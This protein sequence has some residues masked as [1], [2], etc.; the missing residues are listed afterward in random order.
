MNDWTAHGL[1]SGKPLDYTSHCFSLA[2]MLKAD[3]KSKSLI[4]VTDWLKLS[5]YLK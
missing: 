5:D 2:R 3:F 1:Y 4:P